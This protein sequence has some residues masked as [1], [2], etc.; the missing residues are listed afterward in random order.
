MKEG[1]LMS[2]KKYYWLKLKKD[3]FKRHDIQIIEA[4]PN[5][6]DYILFYLKMLVESVDHEGTLKF[7]DTIPYNESMLATITN[8]N[9]DIVRSAMKV[10]TELKMIEVLEDKSIFML[11]VEKMLGTETYW[12]EQKRKQKQL[13]LIE[14]GKCPENVHTFSNES[15]QEL[16]IDIEI[17]IDIDKEKDISKGIKPTN[18]FLVPSIEDV[19][20]YC[21]ERNNS[22]D[23]EKF[24]DFYASKG[25]M[26]GKNKMKDWKAAVRTWERGENSGTANKQ[27]KGT[28]QSTG[29][30]FSS[31]RK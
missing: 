18:K 29:Y 7:N 9:I 13:K 24:I 10:F 25:W 28:S 16:D 26:I 1:G 23:A 20:N 12:A 21:I 27:D 5:G 4:M 14:S 15:N 22:V 8:T 30:D 11:E 31:L 3:F 2:D 19:K 6:K 17:D